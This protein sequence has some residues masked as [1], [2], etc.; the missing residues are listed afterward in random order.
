MV[1]LF[2]CRYKHW[3]DRIVSIIV[4]IIHGDSCAG[5]VCVRASDDNSSHLQD[6]CDG[7]SGG[8]P[9]L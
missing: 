8:E 5:G 9:A 3:V 1:L 4:L 2:Y 6:V 7:G